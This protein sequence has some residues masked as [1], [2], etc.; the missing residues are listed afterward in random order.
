MSPPLPA[1]LILRPVRSKLNEHQK[2]VLLRFHRNGR[3]GSVCVCRQACRA[4]VS[5]PPLKARV[6]M[7]KL[8]LIVPIPLPGL[9]QERPQRAPLPVNRWAGVK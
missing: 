9:T 2:F 3:R 6:K 4:H 7:A 1:G 8:P 5:P